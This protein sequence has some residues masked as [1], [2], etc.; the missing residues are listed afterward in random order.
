VFK[1]SV[2]SSSELI[3]I[4]PG[5][6]FSGLEHLI[7]I[8]EKPL[9]H[10]T[11]FEERKNETKIYITNNTAFT[12]PDEVMKYV[13]H[14]KSQPKVKTTKPQEKKSKDVSK[15]PFSLTSSTLDEKP[16]I[17]VRDI[18]L[19]K[20]PLKFIVLINSILGKTENISFRFFDAQIDAFCLL[21]EINLKEKQD[22]H[23]LSISNPLYCLQAYFTRPPPVP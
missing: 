12:A 9:A 21:N 1:V 4:A 18:P 5:T 10:Q 15:S 8:N 17:P 7:I 20:Q 11:N 16:S 2:S 22:L 14:L 6:A 13:V 3:Y 19:K 23:C